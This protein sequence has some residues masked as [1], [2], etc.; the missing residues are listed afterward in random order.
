M[1]NKR[2]FMNSIVTVED[3]AGDSP[4][5][6]YIVTLL[7]NVLRYN[8]A[9]DHSRLGAAIHQAVQTRRAPEVREAG[10]AKELEEVGKSD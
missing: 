3:P 1:G 6:R 10:S 4:S 5:H 8:S 2:N 7:S 9:W